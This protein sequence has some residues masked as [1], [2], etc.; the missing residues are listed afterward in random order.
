MPLAGSPHGT[1]NSVVRYS[2]TEMV[3]SQIGHGAASRLMTGILRSFIASCLLRHLSQSIPDRAIATSWLS[4]SVAA[5]PSSRLI[6]VK[7]STLEYGDLP[8]HDR[9]KRI[10]KFQ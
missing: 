10:C 2:S 7:A 6:M 8:G 1:P 4:A 5:T 3:R 9:L